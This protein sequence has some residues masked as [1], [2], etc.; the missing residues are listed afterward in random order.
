MF[1]LFRSRAKAVRILLGGMLGVIALSL[2]SSFFL[3]RFTPA[4]DSAWWSL[5]R[6][7]FGSPDAL[8]WWLASRPWAGEVASSLVWLGTVLRCPGCKPGVPSRGFSSNIVARRV[9]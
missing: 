7:D 8:T 1:D 5:V 2:V 9:T 3:R 4:A 6:G